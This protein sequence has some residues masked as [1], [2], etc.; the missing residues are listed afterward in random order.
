M[1]G[2]NPSNRRLRRANNLT[3]YGVAS[4][5]FGFGIPAR[6]GTSYHGFRLFNRIKKECC[7]TIPPVEITWKIFDTLSVTPNDEIEFGKFITMSEDGTFIA[8]I[9]QDTSSQQGTTNGKGSVHIFKLNANGSDYTEVSTHFPSANHMRIGDSG[10][11]S[12]IDISDDGLTVIYQEYDSN[13]NTGSGIIIRKNANNDQFTT[14][15]KLETDG[16]G[17]CEVAISGDASRVAVSCP[18]DKEIDIYLLNVGNGQYAKEGGTL[19]NNNNNVINFGK[20]LSFN[21]DGSRL[22]VGTNNGFYILGNVGMNNNWT[23][24]QEFLGNAGTA[25]FMFG[26]TVSISGDG[27]YIVVSLPNENQGNINVYKKDAN[28]NTFTLDTTINSTYGG[29]GKQFA[30][31]L[32]I[33][34]DGSKIIAGNYGWDTPLNNNGMVI[35]YKKDGNNWV[36][37]DKVITGLE[38]SDFFGIDVAISNDGM[39]FAGGSLLDENGLVRI[40]KL[41]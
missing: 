8:V 19:A 7:K 33:S 18:D 1:P 41:H 6:I 39:I 36:V 29:M 3:E 20:T 40:Y 4:G 13:S 32:A 2:V 11:N 34:K 22:V 10:N 5:G 24:V 9:A 26:K 30:Y 16:D 31:S 35:V 27:E 38:E 28:D 14:I 25:G 17:K 12:Q 21:T 23:T 15:H 37:D